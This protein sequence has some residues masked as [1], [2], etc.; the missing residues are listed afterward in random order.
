MFYSRRG[1]E[2]AGNLRHPLIN[3]EKSVM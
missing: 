3:A 1:K 2:K